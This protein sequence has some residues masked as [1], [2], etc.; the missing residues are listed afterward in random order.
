MEVKFSSQIKNKTMGS[1]TES[2]HEHSYHAIENILISNTPPNLQQNFQITG[3][4]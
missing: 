2:V 3:P 1:T 4:E